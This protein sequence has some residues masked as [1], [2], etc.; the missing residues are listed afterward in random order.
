[1]MRKLAIT[2]VLL[3]AAAAVAYGS[4]FSWGL[5]GKEKGE[6]ARQ[7]RIF[8][9]AL[10]IVQAQ[11]ADEPQPAALLQAALKGMAEALDPYSGFMDAQ[12][13]KELRE[14]TAG[15]F[16]GIGVEL[17]AR[18][19]AITV[20]SP[21]EGSPAWKAGLMPGD[22]ILK[23]D[24][25]PAQELNLLA[26]VKKIRG[27]PGEALTLSVARGKEP[28]R[29]FR[30]TRQVI[31][32]NDVR[33]AGILSDGIAYLRVAEFRE[34]TFPQVEAELDKL[35]KQGMRGL[36]LDLRNN[37][38]GLLESAIETAEKFLP[39]GRLIAYT[40]GRHPWQNKEYLARCRRPL[41]KLPLVILL[42]AGSASGS[43]II[44]ACLQDYGRAK[45]VG[46][47]SFGKGSL[48]TVIP[49]GDGSALRLTTARYY[50]PHGRLIQ[51]KGV[52]PD[53]C[54]EGA[55]AQLARALI[56]LTLTTS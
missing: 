20:I 27:R 41:D 45:I 55:E 48:Q 17:G 16:S 23:I 26:A 56:T 9:D 25:Q 7:A 33:E 54:V 53:I 52:A 30:I 49:L 1:M 44:A 15:K 11:Y 19:G 5:G 43:E 13:Y 34:K 22:K 18:E 51:E 37:P 32:V 2:V 6:V 24:G 36:V 28:E 12:E 14:H 40:K 46:E 29:E 42:N 39:A 8:Q 4:I 35:Q 31:K 38:G 50:S 3:A 10:E 47:K 21:I